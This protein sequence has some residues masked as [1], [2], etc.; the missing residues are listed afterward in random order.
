MTAWPSVYGS[1][2]LVT[3]TLVT[4]AETIV[5]SAPVTTDGSAP[6]FIIAT[7]MVTPGTTTTGISLRLRL[8]SVTGTQV[9]TAGTPT[10][11][12]AAA[13]SLTIMGQ[14][15]GQEIAGRIVHLTLAQVAA[16]A[17]GT[18]ISGGILVIPQF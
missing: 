3:T 2:A 1:T 9:A 16:T 8:D 18:V 4:T 14:I 17:N 10:V 5:L 6:A 7:V 12:A 15:P 11:T 13:T